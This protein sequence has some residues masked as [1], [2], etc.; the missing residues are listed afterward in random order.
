[1]RTAIGVSEPKLMTEVTMSPGWKP[2]VASFACRWASSFDRPPCSRRSASQGI[3]RSG[4]TL[5]S[6]SRNSASLMPLFSFERHAQLAVVGAAH[7]QHHVV[8]AE[9]RRHLAHE[10][11]RDVDV[12][13]LRFVLDLLQALD[14]HLPGQLE[15]RAGRRPEAEHEL[16]RIDLRKQ[17]GADLQPQ[18]PPESAAH[19]A[20]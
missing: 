4:S 6:R 5:R 9:I 10:A 13:G 3:T 1:M 20:R 19:A 18:H 14:G 12:L 8:D 11:H 16:A 2:K 17:L 7:E 15:I